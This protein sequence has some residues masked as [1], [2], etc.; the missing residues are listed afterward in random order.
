[1]KFNIIYADP[2]WNYRVY[3][4]KGLGRSAESHYPTMNIDDI[5]NLPVATIAEKDCIL[6]LWVTFP[7]LLEGLKAIKSWGFEYKTLGFCWVKR[8]KKQTDKWFWG[9]G[10]WTRANPEICL[11]AAKGKPKRL[12]KGVH[13]VIDTPIEGHSKKPNEIRLR[14]VELMG[15]LPRVELFA[16]QKVDGWE[17]LGNEIDGLDI[18]QSILKRLLE[19]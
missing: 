1:M 4:K 19:N 13:S 17:C 7:C 10:F 11:I 12:S 2:P 3:S 5:C 16:R 14:I 9:L 18:T 8:C 6:F 15:D